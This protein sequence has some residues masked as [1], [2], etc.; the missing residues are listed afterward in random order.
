LLLTNSSQYFGAIA[1]FRA[2]VHTQFVPLLLLFLVI[3][4]WGVGLLYELRL[5][6]RRTRTEHVRQL[7]QLLGPN[8]LGI[9]DGAI[10]AE[11]EEVLEGFHAKGD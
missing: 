6:N 2:R 11:K 9:A 8:H 1:V 7:A 3:A 4:I 5:D 10:D